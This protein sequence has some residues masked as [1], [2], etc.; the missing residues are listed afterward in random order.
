[1]DGCQLRC[2][3]VLSPGS[4]FGIICLTNRGSYFIYIEGRDYVTLYQVYLP[5]GATWRLSVGTTEERLA[6]AQELL[7][8][9]TPYCLSAWDKDD[10]DM[11][12]PANKVK[13]F[14]N[15]L[16]YYLL[17][18]NTDGI[19]TDYKDMMNG[20]R[21]IPVSS[22]PTS[23]E[24][25][26]YSSSSM[27]RSDGGNDELN[28]FLANLD[29]LPKPKRTYKKK[30]TRYDRVENA[31]KEYGDS[32]DLGP[33]FHRSIVD[34]ENHFVFHDHTYVIDTRLAPQYDCNDEGAYGMDSIWIA[35]S[36]GD[37]VNHLGFYDQDFQKINSE[38]VHRIDG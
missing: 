4:L 22:C 32:A 36:C 12:S 35:Y 30:E 11:Y 10:G 15:S 17:L 2:E 26:V 23:I 13:R 14:L 8:V 18:G 38:A 37:D 28:E 31:K 25:L 3:S 24:N 16:A 9:W 33:L 6:K 19:V 20:K 21:E 7:D 27:G 1:M 34:T 5:N 29:D